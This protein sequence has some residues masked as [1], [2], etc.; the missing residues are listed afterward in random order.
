MHGNDRM[1]TEGKL[2]VKKEEVMVS[3]MYYPNIHLE[4]SRKSQKKKS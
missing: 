1:I 3:F 4:G 2:E